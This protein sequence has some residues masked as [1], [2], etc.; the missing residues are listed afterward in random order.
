MLLFWTEN[1]GSGQQNRNLQ[2]FFKIKTGTKKLKKTHYRKFLQIG[3]A[4]ST[5]LSYKL[6]DYFI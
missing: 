6:H 2:E 1:Y 5:C 3:A 4:F